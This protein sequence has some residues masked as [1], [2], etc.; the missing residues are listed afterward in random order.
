MFKDSY[1]KRIAKLKASVG[2]NVVRFRLKDGSIFSIP[3]RRVMDV[4][5]SC[6]RGEVTTR[7]TEAVLN[8][9]AAS[10]GEGRMYELCQMMQ[11]PNN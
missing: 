7:E 2:S 10:P 5:L 6:F 8:A 9:V 1:R 4:Y 11:E 3:K